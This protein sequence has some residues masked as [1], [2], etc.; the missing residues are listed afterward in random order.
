MWDEAMSYLYDAGKVLSINEVVR[1][2]EDFS[3]FTGSHWVV[4]GIELVKAV[5]GLS[6]L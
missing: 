6:A 1:F 5:E 3:K 2:Q 4:H